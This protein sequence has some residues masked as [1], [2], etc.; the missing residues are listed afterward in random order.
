MRFQYKAWTFMIGA[1]VAVELNAKPF[2]GATATALKTT[3]SLDSA[4]SQFYAAKSDDDKEAMRAV[5]KQRYYTATSDDEKDR[6]RAFFK[7]NPAATEPSSGADSSA[8]SPA[9]AQ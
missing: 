6:I 8:R 3:S 5:I 4:I 2:A 1:L 9:S 7:Q